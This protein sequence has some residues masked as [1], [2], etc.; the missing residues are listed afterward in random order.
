MK[1]KITNMMM[2]LALSIFFTMTAQ[3]AT[4]T[5]TNN[6]DSGAGS[7]RQAVLDAM[8]GDTIDFASTVTGTISLLSGEINIDK[9]LTIQGPGARVLAISGNNASRI[10]MI[11]SNNVTI[12]ALTVTNGYAP[13]SNGNDGFG[14]AISFNNYSGGVIFNMDAVTVSNSSASG[15]G[16]GVLLAGITGTIKNSTFS[17]NTAPVLG[18]GLQLQDG[19]YTVENSTFSG[20]TGGF[21]GGAIFITAGTFNLSSSTI[22]NNNA[23]TYFF[24]A[25]G[26]IN[27][28]A[29]TIN[30][31]NTIVAGNT[32]P[33]SPDLKGDFNSLGYN[34]IGNNDGSNGFAAGSPNANN[35]YVGTS[36]S[37]INP[38]LGALQDNGGPT[39]THALLSGSVAIDNGNSTLT[40]DQRGST[41]PFDQPDSTYPDA[42]NASDIG[43]FELLTVS[44]DSDDDGVLDETDNC[45]MTANPDQLDTDGDSIGNACDDDDDNDGVLDTDDAFPLDPTESV[46]T[47]G[48]GI[49]N[50]ADTDDDGDGQTDADEVACG[51]NPLNAAS[52]STD[53]DGDNRPNCVDPDD[54]G[55]GVADVNDNCPLTPNPNQADFDRDGI[56]DTCDEQTGPPRDKEQ[57]KNGGWIRFNF[58]RTFK[59][60]G[61]CIQFV[62]TGK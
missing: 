41:R 54:D 16:G 32:A 23:S 43:A 7:L 19:T 31:S 14:G 3:A 40:T 21:G 61:D 46:D 50:N 2:I 17:G 47:D 52:K 10:F 59:N 6:A 11:S 60:Q 15:G 30:I 13:P 18:G 36:T 1:T 4:L 12:N 62:N 44:T 26:G 37:P 22:T 57:C 45:P 42:A 33:V 8:P 49:G 35:D 29:A 20:N 27:N 48:D 51:S 53:T 58:P 55:D 34:L 56:G 28:N 5:V 25:G 24:S 39:D 9:D 38:M